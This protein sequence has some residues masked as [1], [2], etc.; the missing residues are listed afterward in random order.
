MDTRAT[1]GLPW[2]LNTILSPPYA[3]RPINSANWLRA[4]VKG[5]VSALIAAQYCNSVRL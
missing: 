1:A 2:R 3:T 5:T 4:T